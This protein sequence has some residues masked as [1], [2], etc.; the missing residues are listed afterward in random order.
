MA[1]EVHR[2]PGRRRAGTPAL[3][4]ALHLASLRALARW[5]AA[6]AG[7]QAPGLSLA[8]LGMRQLRLL[9]GL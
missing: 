3:V 7:R 9:A 4:P 8:L 6:A 1:A 2:P 5:Q